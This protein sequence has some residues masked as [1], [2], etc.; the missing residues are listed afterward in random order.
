MTVSVTG[1]TLLVTVAFAVA[2]VSPIVLVVL[3][4]LDFKRGRLW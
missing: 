2:L 1:L 4:V 3:L